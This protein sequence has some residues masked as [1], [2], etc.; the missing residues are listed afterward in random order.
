MKEKYNAR[1]IRIQKLVPTIILLTL[2]FLFAFAITQGFDTTAIV[3]IGNL[4]SAPGETVTA[5]IFINNVENYGTGTM[6]ITYD[7]VV[8]HVTDVS[9]GPD[10]TVTAWNVDNTIGVV[11]ISAWNMQG[12]TGDIIFANVTFKAVRNAG[13]TSLNLSIIKLRDYF[14]PP[15]DIPTTIKNG[16]FSILRPSAPFLIHGYVF[17]DSDTACNNSCVS[18]TNANTRRKWSAKTNHDYNY[19]QLV[20]ASGFDVIE[21]EILQFEVTGPD[22]K[23]SNI[24]NHTVTRD[25]INK[26]GIYNFNI[27]LKLLNIFDTGSGTYPSISGVHIGNFT[28]KHDIEVHQIYTY[29]CAGTGGHSERVIFRDSETGEE[30]INAS[31]NGYQSD[32]HTITISPPVNLLKKHI[33]NYKIITGSYPQ[34]IHNQTYENDDGIITC[35]SFI[36]ANGRSYNNWIPAI[37][38]E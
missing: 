17:Y 37:K 27:T 6:S 19:Y 33:Y 15:N 35:S 2:I 29:P 34:I 13:S 36:D 3:S 31:W 8:V 9:S 25:E 14:D 24:T 1:V 12:V 30:K 16:S 26:G 4:T 28:P 11:K 21:D 20:L 10:S 22:G 23:L 18:I 5:P 38:M 7:P 32:Y